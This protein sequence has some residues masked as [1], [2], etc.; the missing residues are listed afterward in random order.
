LRELP[1]VAEADKRW[2]T[3]LVHRSPTPNEHWRSTPTWRRDDPYSYFLIIA[4]DITE[5]EMRPSL[6]LGVS[7]HP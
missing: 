5:L 4:F 6:G 1:Q 3:I 2:T 7:I